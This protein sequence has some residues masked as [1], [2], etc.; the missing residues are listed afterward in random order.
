MRDVEVVRFFQPVGK[1]RSPNIING[2]MIVECCLNKDRRTL[3][4]LSTRC[5]HSPLQTVPC[6][7]LSH[8]YLSIKAIIHV[9]R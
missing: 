6:K 1:K 9:N 3:T 2:S 8:L 7:A 5:L 4:T